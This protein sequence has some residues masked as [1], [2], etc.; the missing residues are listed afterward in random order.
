MQEQ[1]KTIICRDKDGKEY[2]VTANELVIR[3]S[4]YAVIIREDKVLLVHQWDGFDFPGGGIDPGEDMREAL[5]RE[6]REETGLEVRAGELVACE[7]AF[8]RTES[9]KN[10][11][12][13]LIYLKAEVTGGE[14]SIAGLT[15]LEKGWT[16]DLPQ[17]IPLADLEATKFYNSVDSLQIINTALKQ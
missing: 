6:V 16:Q 2:E 5:V 3:P 13:I 10:L 15:E 11:H 14:L 12:S 17:W 1:R 4:V 7:N 8:Y 9:G